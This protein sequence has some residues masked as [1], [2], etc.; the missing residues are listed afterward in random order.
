ME[1]MNGLIAMIVL[2]AALPVSY[3]VWS[4]IGGR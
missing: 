3:I 4:L 1:V 2:M